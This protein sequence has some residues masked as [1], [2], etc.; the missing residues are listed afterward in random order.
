MTL[1]VIGHWHT[2]HINKRVAYNRLNMRLSH[3]TKGSLRPRVV[4]NVSPDSTMV[5]RKHGYPVPQSG[6]EGS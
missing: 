4:M 5:H 3:A 1:A 2:S 6:L